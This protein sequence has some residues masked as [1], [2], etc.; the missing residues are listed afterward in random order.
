M[1]D[2]RLAGAMTIAL[3]VAM[4]TSALLGPLAFGVVRF[5]VSADMEA[6]LVGGELTTLFFAGPMAIVAGVLRLRG[7]RV[8]P[9]LALGPLGYA[10]Y[11]YIQFI[12]APDYSRYPGNNERWFPLYLLMVMASWILALEAWRQLSLSRRRR[13]HARV[14]RWLGVALLGINS[15]F[16]I[17]WWASIG[18]TYVAGPSAGYR[19]HPT[20]FW[21]VRLM[22]LGFVIPI[23]VVL[24]AGLL[25]RRNWASP[26]GYAFAEMEL[27]LCCAVAGMALRM[28]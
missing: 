26:A 12:L 19:E 25:K 14:A 27:L 2:N 21:L 16:A 18:S 10:I 20:A 17:A 6:Q 7:A 24:G 23:G 3:G 15:L 1:R 9:L 5:H 13:D 11:T 28:L 4:M 8:A 22:D